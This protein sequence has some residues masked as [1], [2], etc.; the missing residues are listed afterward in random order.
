MKNHDHVASCLESLKQGSL[1]PWKLETE[2]EKNWGYSVPK[3][4]LKAAQLRQQFI[5]EVTGESFSFIRIPDK[6]FKINYLCPQDNLTWELDAR[7]EYLECSL[8][9]SKLDRTGSYNQ[10]VSNYIGG[11]EAY[12]SYAGRIK[13]RGDIQKEFTHLLV[14]GTGLGP[15]GVTRGSHTINRLGGAEVKVEE[16]GRAARC[17][18]YVFKSAAQ[19]QEA[20]A[21]IQLELPRLIP[22]LDRRMSEFSGRIDSVDFDQAN[23]KEKYILYV[24]FVAR[25]E[26]FRGHGDI[27]RVTGYAKKQLED[28]LNRRGIGYDLS[29]IAQ[30]HDGDLKPSP[31]NKRGRAATAEIRVPEK[32]F[33]KLL[34]ITADKFLSSVAVDSEGA[35][36]LGCQFYSGMGGEIIPAVYK[37]VQVNPQSPLVSSFQNIHAELDKG[38]VVY[39]VELPNI[40]VGIASTREGLISPVGREALRIMGIQTAR[41]FAASLTAQVL[42]GEFNLALEISR[43]KLYSQVN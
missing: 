37:A 3:N 2:L 15:I 25:F 27:S 11:T 32:D 22:E 36:R 43:E 19:R 23:K 26:N 18:G 1:A 10:L 9:G 39:R 13:V 41:E 21:I 16:F 6:P 5:Q 7:D 38:D 24:E 12:Y 30:G 40:E 29:I 34:N 8:C 42:A 33:E 14:Y 4:F 17:N 28:L 35:K 31:H 20:K